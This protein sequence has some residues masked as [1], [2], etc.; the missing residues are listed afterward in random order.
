MR[1]FFKR[2]LITLRLL[3]MVGAATTA[4]HPAVL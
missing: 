3:G 4:A 1:K 2:L